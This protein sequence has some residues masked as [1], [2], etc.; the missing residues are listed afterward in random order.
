VCIF[1]KISTKRKEDYYI[2]PMNTPI[3][4]I[5]L[6]NYFINWNKLDYDARGIHQKHEQNAEYM[7]QQTIAYIRPLN[8]IEKEHYDQLLAKCNGIIEE[9]YYYN[10]AHVKADIWISNDNFEASLPHTHGTT[11]ILPQKYISYSSDAQIKTLIHEKVH[12]FQRLFPI[13][14][15]KLYLNY[16]KL[17]ISGI[18]NKGY[19]SFISTKARSNPDNNNLIYSES[20]KHIIAKYLT[21]KSSLSE[22]DDKR[23]HP[24]EMMAYIWTALILNEPVPIYLESYVG[25]FNKWLKVNAHNL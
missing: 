11:I 4:D 19:F 6:E 25:E 15:Q 8:G 1:R 22:I 14:C 20:G 24:N 7:I 2:V 23:D 17:K 9:S 5:L 13:V 12:I 16:W 10:L 21:D 18:H 3:H